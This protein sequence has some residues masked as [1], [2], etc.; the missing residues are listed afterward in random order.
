MKFYFHYS[1]ENFSNTYILGPDGGGDA[2]LIDPG[3]LDV[4]LLE[5]IEQ[6]NYYIRWVLI[7]RCQ[8]HHIRGLQTLKRIYD[9]QIYS[10]Q[11]VVQEFNCQVVKP[12]TRLHLNTMTVDVF[13]F[14]EL[15]HDAAVY[16]VGSWLFCGDLLSAGRPGTTSSPYAKEI[17][18]QAL[19]KRF[20][21]GHEDTLIFPGEG[22]PTL[23]R[24][25]KLFNTARALARRTPPLIPLPENPEEWEL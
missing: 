20:F 21:Q 23:M 22:P 12:G 14:P 1:A 10:R 9:A 2:I 11:A 13:C 17:L 25:E 7:T 5:L 8:S 19:E 6:N 3:V 4:A 24:S 18:S 16:K 15:S